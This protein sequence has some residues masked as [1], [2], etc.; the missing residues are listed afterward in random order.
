MGRINDSLNRIYLKKIPYILHKQKDKDSQRKCLDFCFW[1]PVFVLLL[2]LTILFVLPS[3]LTTPIAFLVFVFPICFLIFD[4]KIIYV[5]I[6]LNRGYY[7]LLS[8]LSFGLFSVLFYFLEY[9]PFLK[10]KKTLDE[11]KGYSRKLW[12]KKHSI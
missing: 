2:L 3:L 7:F 8:G 12:E 9:R 5:I 11:I 6:R 10:G 1:L 4:I